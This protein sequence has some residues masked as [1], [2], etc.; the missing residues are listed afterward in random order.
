MSINYVKGSSIALTDFSSRNPVECVDNKCQVCQFV[1]DNIN[2][3]VNAITI[4]DVQNSLLKMPFYHESVWRE[5]QMQDSELKRTFSQLAFISDDG[6]LVCWKPNPY[7]KDFKLIIVPQSPA[8]GLISTHYIRLGIL[9]NHSLR[10]CGIG[11]FMHWT[12]TILLIIA[13]NHVLSAEQ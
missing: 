1:Q 5:A 12:V 7:G 10:K 4:E 2:F 13:Q 3:T 9:S 11:T 6:T 8:T